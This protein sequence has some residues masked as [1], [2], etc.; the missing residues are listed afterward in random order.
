MLQKHYTQQRRPPVRELKLTPEDI[1][2]IRAA[3]AAMGYP[4]R[5]R[6]QDHLPNHIEP[7][8]P[9]P[10]ATRFS[11]E[12]R[13]LGA[14]SRFF[15]FACNVAI[16]LVVAY[17]ALSLIAGIASSIGGT[18]RSA[19]APSQAQPPATSV[20]APQEAVNIQELP[21]ARPSLLDLPALSEPL[22][23][24]EPQPQAEAQPPAGPPRETDAPPPD[25]AAPPPIYG[26][27]DTGD[28]V[29]ALNRSDGHETDDAAEAPPEVLPQP[30]LPVLR[31]HSR[32]QLPK[33][34][35]RVDRNELSRSQMTVRKKRKKGFFLFRAVKAFGKGLAEGVNA[36][37]DPDPQS[38]QWP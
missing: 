20:Q 37:L 2:N 19:P 28:S 13:F 7:P 33:E 4:V 11:A 1:R 9:V 27:P 24:A 31:A 8:R 38:D 10:V 29:R 21:I 5:P 23:E 18:S 17:V 32:R 16:A 3:E 15:H 25:R 34:F 26:Q 36:L 6:V 12:D 30:Q 35:R 14:I 22:P